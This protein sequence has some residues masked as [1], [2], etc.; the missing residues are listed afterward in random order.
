VTTK[1]NS[2]LCHLK[3]E[4]AERAIS[5][6]A[7]VQYPTMQ[8]PTGLK[9]GPYVFDATLDAPVSLGKYPLCVVSHGGGGSH[10]LYRTITTYLAEHGFIVMSIEHLG[11]NRND[12]SNSN[13]DQAAIDRP[14]H[15]RL[16]IDA[17]LSTERFASHVDEERIYMVGHSMGGYTALAMVGGH[18]WSRSGQKLPVKADPRILAAVLLAPSVGW[19]QAPRALADVTVPL[20]VL[21]GSEDRVTPFSKIDHVI[22]QVEPQSLCRVI[23]IANAGHY[24]FIAPFP[25]GMTK[26]DFPPSQDPPGFDRAAF[27][28]RLPI[29]IHTFL[30]TATTQKT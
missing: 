25:E 28:K 15:V 3:I 20:L 19:F 22:S 17:V 23:S 26:P 9:I 21:A 8:S 5:F 29:Q 1:V 16:A 12:N 2:G 10:L 13:T 27:H 6:P 14:H 4:D 24:S 18:P 30:S 7:I 11:D